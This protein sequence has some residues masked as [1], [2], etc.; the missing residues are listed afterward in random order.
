MRSSL[1]SAYTTIG[2]GGKA[3]T[4]T[5]VSTA[6]DLA[7]KAASGALIIGRGSNL[8]VSDSGYG[9][10]VAVNRYCDITLEGDVAIVGSGTPLPVLVG[11]LAEN[12]LSGLEWAIGIPGSV[13]GAVRMNAGAFGNC[14]AER[15]LYADV[16]CR[17]ELRR[18]K[19]SDLGFSYRSSNLDSSDAVIGAAFG[20]TRAGVGDIR[21][22]CDFYRAERRKKQPNK[23]SAGSVFKNPPGVSIG[24]EIDR[25]GL[26]GYRIGNA[27][28]SEEH[29]NIIVNLG[30]ATARDV[31]ELI[32][33]I[34]SE[35]ANI[36]IL[37]EEEIVYIGEF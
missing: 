37:A 2:I 17:G 26:K 34:K 33:K 6:A 23:P 10:T 3:D 14:I 24:A 13:G 32:Q 30:G 4:L 36:N 27:A 11:T 19:A 31:F 16:L 9:G 15:L 35:L 28:V 25:L 18:L 5:E 20:L 12:G 1:L 8:L 29:G 22:R 7:E 21:Q